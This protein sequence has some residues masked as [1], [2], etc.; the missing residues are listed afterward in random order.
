[1]DLACIKNGGERADAGKA[2]GNGQQAKRERR[3]RCHRAG[4]GPLAVSG[5]HLLPV[6][7]CLL[8]PWASPGTAHDSRLTRLRR[9]P[10]GGGARQVSLRCPSGARQVSRR[11]P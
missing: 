2:T 4:E 1:M 5:F 10:A 9:A 8:P 3:S 6:A 7:C 11:C